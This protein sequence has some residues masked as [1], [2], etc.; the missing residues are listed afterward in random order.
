MTAIST[1]RNSTLGVARRGNHDS[2]YSRN[3]SGIYYRVPSGAIDE[4]IMT[5]LPEW[6]EKVAIENHDSVLMRDA[7]AIAW[8]A[9]EWYE[10]ILRDPKRI[11]ITVDREIAKNA[12]RRIEE[13]GNNEFCDHCSCP[14]TQCAC[15]TLGKD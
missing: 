5:A 2:I 3:F 6:M 7:L 9:L 8:E 14:K 13:L 4:E 12:M 10:L 1:L 15:H 11:Q